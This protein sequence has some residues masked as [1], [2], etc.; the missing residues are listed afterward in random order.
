VNGGDG[1]S[2]V[3]QIT[4]QLAQ[5]SLRE[6]AKPED[7]EGWPAGDVVLDMWGRRMII[8]RWAGWVNGRGGQRYS[9]QCG[10]DYWP[11]LGNCLNDDGAADEADLFF[12]NYTVRHL[13]DGDDSVV[14]IQADAVQR[15]QE[16]QINQR[17]HD[18]NVSLLFTEWTR[19]IR[20]LW[21]IS[22]EGTLHSHLASFFAAADDSSDED[23]IELAYDYGRRHRAIEL[24][25]GVVGVLFSLKS[26]HEQLY[27]AMVRLVLE[28]CGVYDVNREMAGC[29]ASP[30]RNRLTGICGCGCDLM[31]S[32]DWS[33][34]GCGSVTCVSHC[35][36]SSACQC[37][38]FSQWYGEQAYDDAIYTLECAGV[39]WSAH[40]FA[41][42]NVMIDDLRL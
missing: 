32:C 4:S 1:H 7:E 23:T 9:L 5:L 20:Q 27:G 24:V 38:G 2:E 17:Y 22:G 14:A 29:E 34:P 15:L 19:R 26:G 36:F 11:P 41:G 3:E 33:T 40:D 28:A 30:N 10:W 39:H 8:F 6:R 35:G 37:S 31:L 18:G 12:V 16:W 13:M 42:G 21:R 25:L